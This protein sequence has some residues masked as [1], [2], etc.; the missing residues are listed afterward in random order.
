MGAT[1]T[2]NNQNISLEQGKTLTLTCAEK[3]FRSNIT[4]TGIAEN[5]EAKIKYNN[6]DLVTVEPEQ[7]VTLKSAGLRAISDIII[8]LVTTEA[9]NDGT[10]GI[11]YTL[12]DDGTFYICSGI[13]DAV[14]EPDVIIASKVNGIPVTEITD[15]AFDGCED[16]INIVLPDTLTNIGERA[17]SRCHSLT[18]I[19]I[20]D[21][22]V[23]LKSNT[24]LM[25]N[26]LQTAILGNSLV[27]IGSSAFANC[28]NL[29]KI[30]IGD[31]LTSIEE[32]AFSSCASLSDVYYKGTE[33]QWEAVTIGS[34][35]DDLIDYATIHYNTS[36]LPE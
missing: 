30:L 16:I 28:S 7:T 3:D 27:T 17:F 22:V 6:A 4:I 2:Y 20:P 5:E 26:S 14:T 34:N 35:N 29:K 31:K 9:L 33:A 25:C 11:K 15:S 24:F 18:T 12:S 8:S 32:S 23:N 21:S 1:I 13:E 10:E 19:K 36:E